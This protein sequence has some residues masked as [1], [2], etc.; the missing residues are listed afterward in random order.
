MDCAISNV[1]TEK[2]KQG[3]LGAVL[4][5]LS[6]AIDTINHE[7]MNHKLLPCGF[8]IEALVVLLSYL[9]ETWERIKSNTSFSS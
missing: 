9:Q 4:M 2:D 8:S 5:N 6:K 3:F 1:D 7:L